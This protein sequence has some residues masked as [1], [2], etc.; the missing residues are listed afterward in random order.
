M[1]K[2]NIAFL[3]GRVSTQ[4]KVSINTE[5]GEY[6]Y[7]MFYID[8]VRSKRSV[9]DQVRFVKHDKPLIMSKE[10]EIL[11]KVVDFKENDVVLIKGVVTSTK[12]QK[13]SFCQCDENTTTE[14][15]AFGNLI[16]IT[17]IYVEKIAS[18][19]SDKQAAIE[20]VVNNREI[21]NQVYLMGTLIT[22][23]KI[24]TT[25]RGNQI[26][27]YALAIN[28][29]FLIRS[30]DPSIKTDWP[31]VKSYGEQARQD[32]IFLKYQSEVI[33]DGFLQA[34][35]VER[36]T[37]CKNCGKIYTWQD[38]AM[39]IVPYEVEYITGHKSKDEVEAEFE[40][41]IEEITQEL[42][43]KGF[44]EEFEEGLKTSDLIGAKPT[45]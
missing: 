14:N 3:Y 4:P 26:T 18:Y 12:I 9:D 23:P 37:T 29:K 11:D 15:E 1:G 19:G 20:D 35:T 40:K 38:H 22:E 6:N 24:F 45:T 34:R 36:K 33:I 28:R 13:S 16:Y 2:Q 43:D 7:G 21:S 10:K 31:F 8:V 41:P 30:D 27:Q 42:Y 39:E 44:C 25:R 5:S 32:K 17:P